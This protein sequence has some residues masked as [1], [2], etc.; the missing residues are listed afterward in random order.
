MAATYERVLDPCDAATDWTVLGNDTVNLATTDRRVRGLKALEFDKTNGAANTKL[1]GAS[2]TVAFALDV[3]PPWHELVWYVY[4]SAL[5]DVD[6]A[7][8]RL[9]TDSSNYVEYR[10]TSTSM[11]EGEFT[12]CR[13][14]VADYAALAGTGCDFSTIVYMVVGVA[15][16]AESDA[17]A[18]I[19]VDHV[20]LA[21]SLGNEVEITPPVHVWAQLTA[22]GSTEALDVTPYSEHTF[23]IVVATIDTTVNVRTEG[24]VDG[25]NWFNL[26]DTGA[27]TQYSANGA[28][29][30]HKSGFRC[31]WVRFTFVSEAGGAAA[32][33]DVDYTGG[34]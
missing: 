4:A 2:K 25:T 15:F 12:L 19:A 34:R 17:L 32:T 33:I 6:Y 16:N 1:A 11:S 26:D 22:A 10:Y 18:N 31:R 7:F 3:E 13:A 23:Q 5:T 29:L 30:M 9:G 8:L 27:D 28:Y 24:S 21:W 14:R 20:S